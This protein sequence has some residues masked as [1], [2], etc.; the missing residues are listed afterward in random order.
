MGSDPPKPKEPEKTLKEQVKEYTTEINKMRR[1]F[2]REC[3]KLE[4]DDKKMNKDLKK[5]MKGNN[6]MVNKRTLAQNILKNQKFILKYKNL[7]AQLQNTM[8]ELQSMNT[9]DQMANVMTGMA[10]IMGNA[11]N[12]INMEQ[13]QN[14]MKTYTT[15]KQRMQLMNE[16]IQDSMD[17]AQ[18]EV[19][20]GDVD[21]LIANM[22]AD[23]KQK[24]QQQIENDMAAEEEI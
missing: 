6:P 14:S 2:Q 1:Q 22:Q 23:I 20:D 15:E 8:F 13:F 17:L 7:D 19:E 11:R 24:K 3:Y 12:K 5:L 10:K 4:M 9:M 21:N 18:D 16:M